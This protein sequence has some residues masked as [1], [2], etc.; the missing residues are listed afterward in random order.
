MSRKIH[1]Q[2][3]SYIEIDD[4]PLEDERPPFLVDGIVASTLTLLYGA[5]KSG[6]S[7]LAAAL[8]VSVANGTE[9]LGRPVNAIGTNRVAIV[10]GDPGDDDHYTRMIHRDVPAGSVRPYAFS[11]PPMPEIWAKVCY[12]I[13]RDQTELCIIDNLVAF[14]PGDVNDHRP[15]RV[16]HDQAI[17][18]LTRDGIAVVLIHHTSEKRGDHGYSKTP[19]GNTAISAAAR[20]KWRVE[21]PDIVGPS[22]LTFEGNY[23][24]T[25][26]M[27]VT[28]PAGAAH[29][30]V[31][32]VVEPDELAQRRRNRQRA[33]LDQR[34]AIGTFIATECQGLTQVDAASKVAQHFGLNP[35]TV[36]T[37]I[38]KGI[39]PVPASV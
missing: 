31:L 19:M 10:T 3:Y 2:G 22:R 27:H 8:A 18:Q 5:P 13:Q 7:T 24:P 38:V 32:E 9:F 17:D 29:F 35:A 11:R 39:Y 16:F 37:Y 14:V 4:K 20:W 33:T 34:A 23:G 12:E 6:K 28:R 30:D 25:H 1:E 21:T 15:V 36:R 26:E